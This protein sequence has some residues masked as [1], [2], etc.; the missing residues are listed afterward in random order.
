MHWH[1]YN[2]HIITRM[3]QI[4]ILFRP[5]SVGYDIPYIAYTVHTSRW[6]SSDTERLRST[7]IKTSS[8]VASFQRAMSLW[9]INIKI[10]KYLGIGMANEKCEN[11][12]VCPLLALFSLLISVSRLGHRWIQLDGKSEWFLSPMGSTSETLRWPKK[13]T[14]CCQR[15]GDTPKQ[16]EPQTLTDCPTLVN[17][18]RLCVRRLPLI[19]KGNLPK[20]RKGWNILYYSACFQKCYLRRTCSPNYCL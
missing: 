14:D 12:W 16:L 6:Q 9:Y 2:V 10:Y 20:K 4:F 17:I 19:H 7:D 11:P 3:W 18:C 5:F 13:T 8:W 15:W 1:S